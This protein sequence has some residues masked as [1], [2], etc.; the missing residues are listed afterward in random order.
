MPVSEDGR[1]R[2]DGTQWLPTPHEVPR[3][4]GATGGAAVELLVCFDTTGSMSDKIKS[5]VRQTATFVNEAV[6]RGLDLRWGLIAFGDLRVEGDRIETY[7]F[8][9]DPAVLTRLLRHMPQF[10]GGGN[11]GETSLDALSTAARHPDWTPQAVHL[12][13]LLTD[14]SPVGVGVDLETV[15]HQLRDQRIV[16]FCV[17]PDHRAYRWLAQ[18]TG[19]EWW[20]IFEPIPFER[21][22]ARLAGTLMALAAS[23]APQL[24]PG[25]GSAPPHR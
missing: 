10:S 19:G 7:P 14:E 4:G 3:T 24:G 2:W 21:L 22:L 16:T 8:T 6:G 1:W 15:G 23:L 18:V 25:P 12:V 13:V 20:D 17:A 9:R 11:R 5:L